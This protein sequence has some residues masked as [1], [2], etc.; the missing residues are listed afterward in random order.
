[1]TELEMMNK[2]EEARLASTEPN[3][4]SVYALSNGNEITWVRSYNYKTMKNYF[5]SKGFWICSIFEHGHRVAA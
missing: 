4:F 1:M 5:E 2:L 3:P